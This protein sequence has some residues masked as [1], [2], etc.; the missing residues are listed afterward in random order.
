MGW[1]AIAAPYIAQGV[2]ALSG[3]LSSRNAGKRGPE[4][5][6]AL[7][8]AQGAAAGLA[9]TGGNLLSTVEGPRSY[10]QGLLGGD[11][12]QMAQATAGPRAAIND[13]YRGAERGIERAGVRG[14]A[15]D[16]AISDLI[17][18]RAAKTAGLVSGVQPMAAEQLTQI[19][20]MG[21]SLLG[22]S[23]TLWANLLG[24]GTSNRQAADQE[25]AGAGKV[26]G[27]YL[28]DLA[29]GIAGAYG[30]RQKAPIPSTSVPVPIMQ[31]PS[32]P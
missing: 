26:A 8:G 22:Q 28:F 3:Y 20:G 27:Q 16:V 31:A 25:K 6:V 18:D 21:Q 10:W 12:A 1:L 4:E 2:G 5:R 13:Q 15:R 19:A 9:K 23:G 11:R 24:Q 32:L 29:S 17:R 14:A 30:K 7:G